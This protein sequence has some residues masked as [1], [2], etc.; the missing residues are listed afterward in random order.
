[1]EILSTRT[2]VKNGRTICD[3]RIKGQVLLAVSM[4]KRKDGSGF[5]PDVKEIQRRI[6]L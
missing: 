6:V 4:I 2:S 1:M 5:Y 3:I